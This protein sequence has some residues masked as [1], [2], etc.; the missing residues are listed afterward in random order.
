MQ[1]G[2]YIH[3]A[4]MAG[5]LALLGWGGRPARADVPGWMD[6][7]FNTSTKGSVTV[8]SNGVWT[9]MG[10][11]AD[12]WEH[13]DQFHIVYKPLKGDGSVTTKLLSAPD[14]AEWSKVGVIMR[15][16][17]TNKAAAVMEFHMTTQHGGENLIRGIDD[18]EN[19][20]SPLQGSRMAKD[21]KVAPG[22]EFVVPRQFPMWFRIVRQGDKFTAYARAG[23]NDLWNP[24]SPPQPI[25]MGDSIVAGCFV[26]SVSDGTL[27][28][29]TFD[30]K[31]TDAGN[32]L[33]KP[34]E[35]LPRQPWPV[36]VQGG[37]NSVML[38]WAPVDHFGHPA[39][40]YAVYKAKV[41]DTNLTKIADLPGDKTSYLDDQIKNGE[42][43]DYVVTTIVK[44]GS[45][46]MESKPFSANNRLLRETS[47]PNPPI[48]IGNNDYFAS[49]L[50]GGGPR[51][52]TD[53][54][55]FA[56]I[57]ANGVVT[58]A[59]SGEDIQDRADGGEDLLTPV[60]G[61]FTFTARVLGIP[62]LTDGTDANEWA[63]YGIVVKE[64]TLA[65]SRYAAMF[66]TPMHGIRS[67]HR[68]MFTN[69]FTD[70]VGPNEDTPT[71]PI[72]F[73]LQRQGD[74]L[75][76]FTSADGNT[77]KP[78]GSPETLTMPDLSTD[79]Y[80]GFMGDSDDNSQV[81]Q[82]KFDKVTLTTP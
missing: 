30:G 45:T 63:K 48:K 21:E 44:I 65:E 16:D 82:A 38:T 27:Q 10:D 40:G 35:A 43:A 18:P 78:Y 55:G 12:T 79:V 53:T 56:K 3:L 9:I 62:T 54:P 59:A 76:V 11:G 37:D 49:L 1:R 7:D 50:D 52:H 39:D 29:G 60:H 22:G 51:A 32:T 4:L 8:D 64:N 33:P 14:G 75:K 68:R 36:A 17:L 26:C 34:E 61:D 58:L 23:D 74:T 42:E 69:G 46:T 57:D 5:A 81:A 15:N 20:A 73:R 24:V 71:F 72:Y 19:G 47:S 41:G 80:V 6:Q 13:D 77:F 2:R 66:I 67:P 70:D 28:M 25:A 31:V